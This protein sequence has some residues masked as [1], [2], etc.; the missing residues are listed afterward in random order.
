MVIVYTPAGFE[1]SFVDAAAM[2]EEGKDRSEIG[3]VL[4]ETLWADTG[5]VARLMQALDEPA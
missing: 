4:L 3:R 5:A 1:R 2:V